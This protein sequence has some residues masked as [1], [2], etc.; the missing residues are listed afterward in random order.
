MRTTL[1]TALVAFAVAAPAATTSAAA[2]TGAG[3][4]PLVTTAWLAEHAQD[5]SL[6][7]LHVASLR[8]DYAQ[9]HVPG[10]RY[11]WLG[12]IAQGTPDMSFELVPLPSLVK[13]FEALGVTDRSTVVLCGVNGNVSLT[14]RAFVTLEYLGLAGRVAILDGGFDAWKA[15]GR[16]VSTETPTAKRSS[17]HPR[18]DPSVF[19]DAD[20]VRAHLQSAGVDIVDARAPQF[21]NGT[22]AGQPRAGQIPGARN[23]YFATLVDSTNHMLPGSKLGELFDRAGV[24]QGTEVATYCHVGQTAS[25]V[26]FAARCVGR[27]AHLYDGSFDEWGGRMDLPIEVPAKP[28][29][30]RH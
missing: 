9:G 15:D 2:T 4:A 17:F 28:N 27:K 16:P 3:I 24:R 7:V 6:I 14:A 1:L 25:L 13:T 11:L 26:Y 22:S 29:S 10:A 12:A 20:W 8:R 23:L 30:S 18:T 21:Y 5:P 19:V